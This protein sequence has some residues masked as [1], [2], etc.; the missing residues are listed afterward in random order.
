MDNATWIQIDH[1][2]NSPSSRRARRLRICPGAH[3]K[4]PVP[5]SCLWTSTRPHRER[6]YCPVFP[7]VRSG[8]RQ[9]ARGPG[10]QRPV[11]D[12]RRSR[13]DWR[14]W[15]QFQARRPHLRPAC[16]SQQ[17][18]CRQWVRAAERGVP[19]RAVRREPPRE[20]VHDPRSRCLVGSRELPRRLCDRGLPSGRGHL[21]GRCDVHQLGAA[22]WHVCGNVN[23]CDLRF[24]AHLD[25]R[26]CDRAASGHRK[27]NPVFSI[28]HRLRRL[29]GDVC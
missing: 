22:R 29:C 23:T 2:E 27:A 8:S 25:C 9:G 7:P 11:A 4:L 6:A 5:C 3:P 14:Q 1:A 28:R 10:W 17:P 20:P 12:S 15:V 13:R 26:N 19:G 18:D 16:A 24:V 21:P